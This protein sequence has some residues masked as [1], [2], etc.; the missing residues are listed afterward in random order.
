M[1]SQDSGFGQNDSCCCRNFWLLELFLILI[2]SCGTNNLQNFSFFPETWVTTLSSVI[3]ASLM[4]SFH[5][6]SCI[7]VY[8]KTSF[9][10]SV[11]MLLPFESWNSTSIGKLR[12]WSIIFLKLLI[13][14]KEVETSSYWFL[15]LCHHVGQEKH[16]RT[17]S[18]TGQIIPI[19]RFHSRCLSCFLQNDKS[20]DL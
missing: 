4:I 20:S 6:P 7:L 13:F 19:L 15:C 1:E 10:S 16:Q 12:V 3:F 18:R 17:I 8:W 2:K 9:S 5:L 14:S 11:S